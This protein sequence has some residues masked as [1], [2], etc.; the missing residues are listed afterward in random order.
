MGRKY[1]QLDVCK[2]CNLGLPDE[3]S[4]YT[5]FKNVEQIQYVGTKGLKEKRYFI[6]TIIEQ[7]RFRRGVDKLIHKHGMQSLSSAIQ[8]LLQSGAFSSRSAVKKLF[9]GPIEE[10]TTEEAA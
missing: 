4:V 3:D 2:E 6:T 8:N 5:A 7:Q 10:A 1:N 9:P